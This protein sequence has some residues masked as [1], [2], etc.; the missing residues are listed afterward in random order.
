MSNVPFNTVPIQGRPWG[1]AAGV[2]AAIMSAQQAEAQKH[3][4]EQMYI[5]NQQKQAELSRYQQ[6]T[7]HELDKLGLESARA[8]SLATPE[9]VQ[10][11]G[12]GQQGLWQTQSA[13]GKLDQGTLQ[14]TMDSSNMGNVSKSLEDAARYLEMNAA[15]SPMFG[16]AEYQRFRNSLPANIQRSFPDMYTPDIPKQIK[17]LSEMLTNTPKHRG[18]MALE[19][20][21]RDSMEAANRYRSD[22]Q[23]EIALLRMDEAWLRFGGSSAKQKVESVITRYLNKK[24]DGEKTTPQED[25]T[26]VWAQQIMM[27]VKAAAGLPMDPNALNWQ[28]MNPGQPAPGRPVPNPVVPSSQPQPG[29]PQPGAG[30]NNI[31]RYNSQTGRIE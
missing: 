7:P 31:R 25:Q 8:R 10:G 27:N 21:R 2:E 23:Y 15:A 9:M 24:M 17:T 28:M 26:F 29:Q 13:K 5:A 4:L 16:Q 14:S 3:A 19:S 1:P 12:E 11:Y 30:A 22:T 18:E 20:K 6:S